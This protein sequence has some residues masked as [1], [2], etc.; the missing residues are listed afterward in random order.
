[1]V[2]LASNTNLSW[3]DRASLIT[4]L[5]C[6]PFPN[7]KGGRIPVCKGGPLL[8]HAKIS[9]PS[10]GLHCR[11]PL[12][13]SCN[14]WNNSIVSVMLPSQEEPSTSNWDYYALSYLLCLDPLAILMLPVGTIIIQVEWQV[15]NFSWGSNKQPIMVK[16]MKETEGGNEVRKENGFRVHEDRNIWFE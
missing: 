16:L 15:W 12:S 5:L 14:W 1:M 11:F 3:D 9:F 2:Q 6:M 7:R 13:I 8:L 10:K 4:Q